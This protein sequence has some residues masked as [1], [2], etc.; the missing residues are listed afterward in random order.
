[1]IEVVSASHLQLNHHIII[2]IIKQTSWQI[3]SY[4]P[5]KTAERM[6]LAVA[7]AERLMT[8]MTMMMMT[9]FAT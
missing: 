1:M 4:Q 8:R 2:I 3:D 5:W 7:A 6:V 9:T